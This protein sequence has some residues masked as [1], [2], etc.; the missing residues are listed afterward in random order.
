MLKQV[1]GALL[2]LSI[3]TAVFLGSC[4]GSGS[5]YVHSAKWETDEVDLDKDRTFFSA[6][7]EGASDDVEIVLY[8]FLPQPSESRQIHYRMTE[9]EISHVWE[10]GGSATVSAREQADGSQL[11]RIHAIGDTPWI[12]LSEYRVTNN[13]IMP[14]RH[15]ASNH[16]YLL[17]MLLSPVITWLALKPVRRLVWMLIKGG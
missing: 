15:G 2:R 4:V 5:L 1:I 7:R 9:Q 14:L 8:R 16:S 11:I 12:S 17:G 10:G 3:L 13:E 6:Y